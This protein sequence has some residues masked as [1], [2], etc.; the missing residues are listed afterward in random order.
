MSADNGSLDFVTSFTIGVACRFD[1]LGTI[2][3]VA[4]KG[5]ASA[6]NAWSL[7]MDTTNLRMLIDGITNLGYVTPA[8][9]G[10]WGRYIFR[11]DGGGV[12][13]AQRLR[14][15]KNGVEGITHTG[16]IPASI[17]NG[18]TQDVRFGRWAGSV[19]QYLDGAI[20]SYVSTGIAGTDAQILALDRYLA[21]THP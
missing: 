4:S 6:D 15:W 10:T 17:T 18:A 12:G 1:T 13:N 11:Y 8:A 7:Q 14:A 20:S 19:F 16:T 9:A 5:A 3:V 2:Q 21:T